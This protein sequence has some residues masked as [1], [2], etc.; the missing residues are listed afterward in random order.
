M[1]KSDNCL[2]GFMCAEWVY[3][4]KSECVCAYKKWYKVRSVIGL[5]TL[6]VLWAVVGDRG[7]KQVRPWKTL[8]VLLKKL[9][10]F[11]STLETLFFFIF[12][13]TINL[14]RI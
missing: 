9:V 1:T 5:N 7:D 3:M 10:Y 14:R 11:M 13:I 12:L 8:N 4:S 6:G 2:V